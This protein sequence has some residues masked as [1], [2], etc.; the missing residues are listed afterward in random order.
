VEKHKRFSEKLSLDYSLLSDPEHKTIEEYGFWKLKKM[1]GREYMG[2]IR[3]T[4][5][6]DPEGRIGHIW[7]KVRVRGHAEE[8][9][10]KAR[11]LSA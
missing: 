10:A 5:L 9:L 3:S 4:V 2:V 7:E 11:E 6:I 8:V 1:Y